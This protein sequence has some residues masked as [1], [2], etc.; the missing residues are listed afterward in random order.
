MYCKRLIFVF[1]IVLVTLTF[2]ASTPVT[3]QQ[4]PPCANAD[5]TGKTEKQL[6]LSD[7]SCEQAT[8]TDKPTYSVGASRF[9]WKTGAG[10][11]SPRVGARRGPARTQP[12]DLYGG[13]EMPNLKDL[14]SR[15]VMG[16]K[17]EVLRR[18]QKRWRAAENE[19]LHVYRSAVA[20]ELTREKYI[21][22]LDQYVKQNYIVAQGV[23]PPYYREL[24]P[25]AY[26]K[27][28]EIVS[29]ILA[30]VRQDDK[31]FVR[32]ESIYNR[33]KALQKTDDWPVLPRFDWREKG[34]DVGA[35]LN[36]G[37]CESCWA[38]ATISAY[39][40]TW[41]LEQ[42]RSGE[43]FIASRDPEVPTY[44]DRVASIQQLLNCIGKEKGDCSGGWH[45]SAFAFMVDSHVPHIPDRLVE[46]L[47]IKRL[48]SG[49]KDTL[50][51]VEVEGYTGKP[52]RCVD[53][54]RATKVKRGGGNLGLKN[55]GSAAAELPAN[56]DRK[57]TAFDRALAWGYVNEK[58][59][60]E[61]PAV[62]QLK[63]ALIEYG[64]VVMPLHGDGCFS[65][66]HGGVFNGHHSG[67]PNHVVM[68]IGWDDEKQAW[69]TK[70]SWGQEWGEQGF[71]WIAYGSNDIGKF[72]A[73]IQP[74]PYIQN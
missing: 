3:S 21:G 26:L 39:Q 74:S 8:A 70:N 46:R 15:E 7:C 50:A 19:W 44:Q 23:V 31:N 60:D 71:A 56:S 49:D 55:G 30:D 20:Q 18:R 59:P 14:H 61:L 69:L 27:T 48:E 9:G 45:G 36:Q 34:L 43:Y 41:Y 64:P 40:S 32:W 58:K 54:F 37:D 73:W 13:L 67:D 22:S 5:T 29:Q 2:S 68:L 52:S 62:D 38:F 33:F 10:I 28:P 35:V 1:A 42:L 63:K 6:K 72:A 65:V 12:E 11:N 51:K 57:Q 25:E 66:Y 47:M 16:L 53:V 4:T 17:E 24:D